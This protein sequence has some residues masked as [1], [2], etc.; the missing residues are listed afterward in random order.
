MDSRIKVVTVVGTR[1]EI[2]RLSRVL[3]MLDATCHHVLIHTGQNYDFELNEIF[4][5]DLSLRKPDVVLEVAGKTAMETIAKVLVEVEK[6]LMEEKPDAVLVL[7]DTNSCLSILAA[8]RL[9][10]PTFHMEAGNRCFDDRVPEEINRR[11]VD[12]TSDINMPYSDIARDY[13]ISEGIPAD[14]IVKTG[15]PMAEVLDF[16]Q[17]KIRA[18]QIL[19]VL[20]IEK[21]K[22]FLVSCHREENI[23]DPHNLHRLIEILEYL[24]SLRIGPVL[25]STH[26]RL[27]KNLGD[28]IEKTP[29]EIKF[30]KPMGFTDYVR[31]QIDA[32]TVLS[33][34]GTI[35]EEASILDFSAI[36]IRETHERPESMEEGNVIFT[37][38]DLQ[39]IQQGLRVVEELKNFKGRKTRIPQD[40]QKKL[41]S[42]QV[43]QVILSYTNYVNS[44]VWRLPWGQRVG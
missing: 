14:R 35:S 2:I 27:R 1:P 18:S 32:A 21:G 16:Y 3:P 29:K 8:K 11:I 38:L 33:D 6:V 12:H 44:R 5:Q 43:M 25:V 23:D 26:P 40:Y 19:E 9:K 41:V 10:I 28:L 36:N 22:Y 15:S 42:Y 37:G 31:L 20:Q 4:F 34:S 24:A 7:G 39:R 13:L 30:L 17:E